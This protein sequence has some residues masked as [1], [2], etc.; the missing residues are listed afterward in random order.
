LKKLLTPIIRLL[1]PAILFT[2]MPLRTV[3]I[4]LADL[5]IES[6]ESESIRIRD[7]QAEFA[8]QDM[9]QLQVRFQ[10]GSVTVAELGELVDVVVRCNARVHKDAA[11]VCS[12]GTV[13]A[14]HEQLGTVTGSLSFH[15]RED[16]RLRQLAMDLQIGASGR[17]KVGYS[18]DNSNAE[19]HI[20]ADQI[21]LQP[22]VPLLQTRIPAL[23]DHDITSGVV[24]GMARLTG[25]TDRFTAIEAEIE[26][27][28]FSLEGENVLEQ[29]DLA[30]RLNARRLNSSWIINS[31]ARVAAGVMYLI[32]G[33]KVFD[34]SP[35][36]YIDATDEGLQLAL[37]GRV[38][39]DFSK[40]ALESFAYRHGDRL[41]VNGRALIELADSPYVQH[42]EL[43][44]DA[45]DLAG[46]FPVYVQPLLL[47][48]NF[49][50]LDLAGALQLDLRYAGNEL[51]RLGLQLKDVYL[52]DDEQR[53]SV[54]GLNSDLFIGESRQMRV[55]S[56]DWSSLSLFKLIFGA[57]DITLLSGKNRIEVVDWQDVDVL[58]GR[59]LI[60]QLALSGIGSGD[61]SLSLHGELT[62][63]SLK[64]FTQTM[65]WPLMSG[66]LSG[67]IEDFEYRGGDLRING[68]L[69]FRVFDGN[70]ILQGLVIENLFERNARFYTDVVIDNLDLEQLTGTFSF[71]RIE[72]SLD[73]HVRKLTLL[74][75][76]PVYFDA[77]LKSPDDDQ[78]PHRI[79]QKALDNLSEIGGGLSRALS[80][81]FLRFVDEYS[82][83]R[84]GLR[85]LLSNGVCNLGGIEQT[86]DGFYIMT[87]GGLLPPWVDV[88]GTGRSIIWKD[89]VNGLKRIAE[90]DIAFD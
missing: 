77:V 25:T 73:G 43:Y 78:R 67:I 79:S 27:N 39:S 56:L 84:L 8:F 61:F 6:V 42:L 64:N 72:G 86:E 24:G 14:V 36:F 13:S 74:D 85:C 35:G 68:D 21:A 10:A 9:D 3:A 31:D 70:V 33:F 17:L 26:L 65:G 53:F 34:D 46:I 4:D 18:R 11:L 50:D 22:F 45:V 15:L 80:R 57:G 49:A 55:S 59:L 71:G 37:T 20:D 29:T 90:G 19:L 40:L 48:T 81:G 60:N 41:Q 83:G 66:R 88:K 52:D 63:V 62:P 54:S 23:A 58:D 12:S 1:C 32:P 30:A 76:Q 75:W 51:T 5:I 82:Y 47:P 89:L 28:D 7:L 69:K 2:V 16:Y 44:V 38:E 87:R